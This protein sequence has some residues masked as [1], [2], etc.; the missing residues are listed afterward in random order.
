MG[1]KS[2]VVGLV[3]PLASG[4][5]VVAHELGDLGAE[6]FTADEVNRDLLA[7]DQPLLRKVVEAF[8]PGYLRP[9][10]SL[11]RAALGRRIFED[12]ADRTALEAIVHPA[13]T[14][15]LARRVARAR[16]AGAPFV[17]VEAAVLHKMGAAGLVDVVVRVTA[18]R[19]ERLR[20]LIDRDGLSVEEAERRLAVHE[21]LGL[22]DVPAEH[23]IDTTEGLEA[24]R[25]QVRELWEKLLSGDN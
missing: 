9:D 2:V 1:A 7:P 5:S 4:K 23:V 3:G 14:E 21:R 6:V 16:A 22:D 10:G 24:T 11:D 18:S 13:M 8:G 25:K 19:E 12:E 15:E 17:V 20:R